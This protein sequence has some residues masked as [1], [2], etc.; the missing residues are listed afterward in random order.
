M[1]KILFI[2]MSLRKDSFN[3]KFVANAHRIFSAS[4]GAHDCELLSFGYSDFFV[5]GIASA[6]ENC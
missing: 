1:A 2:A 3:K 6:F 4:P 5:G